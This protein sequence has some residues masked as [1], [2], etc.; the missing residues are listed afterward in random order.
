LPRFPRAI[1]IVTSPQAAA[2]RD[3]L[4]T[5]RAARADGAGDRR[6]PRRCRAKAPARQVARAI[7]LAGTRA[8]CDVL[9]VGRGGGSLEDLWAFNEESWRAPFAAS[10]VPVVKRGRPRDRLHHRRLRGRLARGTPTAAAVA[11]SPDRQALAR[12]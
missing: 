4:T 7:R 12:R 2:L 1:G 3:L 5:L 11:A 6:T 10:P 9:I 8:E